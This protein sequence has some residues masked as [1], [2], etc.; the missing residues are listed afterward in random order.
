MSATSRRRFLG[1]SLALGAAGL[2][3]TRF[4]MARTAG[5]ARF[6]LIILRGALDGLAAVPPHGDPNYAALRGQLAIAKPGSAQGA[7]PLDADFGLHPSLGFLHRS[8]QARELSVLHAVATPYRERSHFDAQDVLENGATRAHALQTGWLNRTL[9]ALPPDSRTQRGVAL[10]ANVPLVMRG[11]ADVASWSPTRLAALDDDTLQRIADLYS[12]DPLL[13]GRFADALST[14]AIAQSAQS[15]QG[16]QP[17][18]AGGA[19]RN[20]AARYLETV[21]AAAGFLVR[22]DGPRVAVF[23]TTGWDTHANEGGAEGQLAVRL[24]AL[25][26]GLET[27]K[28]SLGPVWSRSVVM[29]VTEFGRTVAV[30]G[31]RGTDHGTGAAAFVLGG[32]VQG[33]RVRADWPGLAASALYEGRDLRPTLDL[34]SAFKGVLRDHLQVPAAA[35][36]TTI[37][38]DSGPVRPLEDLIRA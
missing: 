24:A 29:L 6:V 13:A 5:D 21:R 17:S 32:A 20:G 38:P 1:H 35:L 31:T 7:L 16:G 9:T 8:F 34:R 36:D 30:N 14:D 28:N 2:L 27:L 15:A 4:A 37:F 25:D 22:E 11:P 19:Q 3:T 26:S 12:M 18:A 33:G 10:G 23:E